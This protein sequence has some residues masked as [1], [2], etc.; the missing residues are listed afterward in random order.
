MIHVAIHP[1]SAAAPA[2]AGEFTAYERFKA[3]VWANVLFYLICGVLGFAGLVFI[4]IYYGPTQVCV[5]G[6]RS[7]GARPSPAYLPPPPAAHADN[8]A[9][10]ADDI[11]RQHVRA[12]HHGAAAR[13]R[14]RRVSAL[15]AAPRLP[16]YG[17]GE[18]P[19]SLSCAPPPLMRPPAP[20]RRAFFAAPEAENDLFD[21]RTELRTAAAKLKSLRAKVDALA[22]EPEF[23]V[24]PGAAQL[25][26]LH[27]ALDVVSAVAEQPGDESDYGRHSGGGG[28]SRSAPSSDDDIPL[29]RGWCGRK[30]SA[31]AGGWR[32]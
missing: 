14:H 20:Q 7:R 9:A 19:R 24:M 26:K 27:R 18:A 11:S 12:R 25:L 16:G 17:A 8:A 2:A 4:L 1:T 29:P 30:A 5:W 3:A 6:G 13:L 23:R 32:M 10:A 31:W 15:A 21:A 28:G 22:A